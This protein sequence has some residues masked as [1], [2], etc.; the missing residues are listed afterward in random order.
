MKT[1]SFRIV[2][3]VAKGY[4]HDLAGVAE[5]GLVDQVASLWQEFAKEEFDKSNTYVS[6]VV[7]P[8]CVVYHQDWGCPV[9][10]E[11]VII[12]SGTA[13]P[14][15]V[16][17]LDAWKESVLSLAKQLKKELKQSTLSVEFFETDF[18]YLTD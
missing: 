12:L 16:K 15:F 7:Q 4:Y 5:N 1:L 6:A 11:S 13:N 3:G 9:S 10:G 14:Q 8:G 2:T 17:D 18:I